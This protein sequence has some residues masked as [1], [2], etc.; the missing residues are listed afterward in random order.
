MFC[1]LW[2]CEG[3]VVFGGLVARAYDTGLHGCRLLRSPAILPCHLL[4]P[5]S[6]I[7]YSNSLTAL[8][9]SDAFYPW[10]DLRQV[11]TRLPCAQE[12]P[13]SLESRMLQGFLTW[14][15]VAPTSL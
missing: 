8:S 4:L 14:K 11:H 2:G 5:L 10:S 3:C 1:A 15:S 7:E 6:C 12:V 13:W 9:L